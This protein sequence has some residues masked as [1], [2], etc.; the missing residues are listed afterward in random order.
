MKK[1]LHWLDEYLEEFVLVIG[2]ILMTLIM[3]ILVR[4]TDPVYLY[5]V[6]LLKCQLLQQKMSF[7]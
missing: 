5:L 2:L 4:R 7:Y 6:R 1:A 3:G